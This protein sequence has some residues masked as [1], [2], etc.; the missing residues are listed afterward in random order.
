MSTFYLDTRTIVIMLIGVCIIQSIAMNLIILKRKTYPG[1]GW[2]TAGIT[3]FG[4]SFILFPMRNI[5][6]DIFSIVLANVLFVLATLF[7]LEGSRLFRSKEIKKLFIVLTVVAYTIFQSYFTFVDNEPNIRIIVISFLLGTIFG[8]TALELFLKVPPS[9][10]FFYWITGTLFTVFSVFMFVRGVFTL[11]NPPSG[12]LLAPGIVHS[13]IFI[14]AMFLGIGWAIMFIVLNA[15]KLENELESTQLQ[16]Q[17]MATTD[18]LTGI[19]NSR[20]F[21]ELGEHEIQR[22]RRHKSSLAVLMIDL[23]YFKKVND[24]Y[25]HAVGDK[26]L[27]A[28]TDICKKNLRDFDIFGRLGGEEFAILLP[29]TETNNAKMLAERLCSIVAQSDVEAEDKILH[30]T[31]SIGVSV[32]LSEEDNLDT[33]LRRADDAMYDAKRKGRNQVAVAL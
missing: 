32:L 20:L 23:D 16:F 8:L 28:F 21:R 10:R 1:F 3:T 31:V 30:I 17:K 19:A 29:Q 22:T 13:L 7:F 6:P 25:G 2:W 12:D 15:E 11:L 4:V 14:M 18:F 9:L 27:V 5:I 24:A 26:V 33:M